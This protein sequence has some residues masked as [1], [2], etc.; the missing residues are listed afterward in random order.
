MKKQ[1]DL[2]LIQGSY[3]AL[4]S[5]IFSPANIDSSILNYQPIKL[6]KLK[7]LMKLNNL[8]ISGCSCDVEGTYEGVV[9]NGMEVIIEEYNLNGDNKLNV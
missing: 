7:G 9:A 8:S 3:L 1:C 2:A 5:L 4:A 6:C